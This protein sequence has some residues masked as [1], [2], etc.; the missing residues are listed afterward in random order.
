MERTLDGVNDGIGQ[1]DDGET[2]SQDHSRHCRHQVRP[3]LAEI[4]ERDQDSGDEGHQR[5][6]GQ[7]LA[8][9]EVLRNEQQAEDEA[10]NPLRIALPDEDLV[11]HNEDERN[12]AHEHGVEWAIPSATT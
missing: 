8:R 6:G 3:H 5:G 9:D 4:E 2:D 12:E 10:Q 1:N 11:E 7:Q